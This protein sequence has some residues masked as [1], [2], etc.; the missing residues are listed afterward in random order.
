MLTMPSDGS[1]PFVSAA[2][3]RAATTSSIYEE[4]IE[5][6]SSTGLDGQG[7]GV[8]VV[9]ADL[10]NSTGLEAPLPNV[11]GRSSSLAPY[12]ERPARPMIRKGRSTFGSI[13]EE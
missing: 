6:R 10:Q 7:C 2:T 12:A 13:A 1:S 4:G 3:S 9:D 5:R 11:T 8:S